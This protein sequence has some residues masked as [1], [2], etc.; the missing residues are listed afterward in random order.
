MRCQPRFSSRRRAA[1]FT[2]I[3]LMIGVLIG[4]LA[5]LAVTQVMVNAEGQKRSTTSGS[6]AQVNGALALRTLQRE[7]A[8][9]GYGFAAVPSVIGCALTATFNAAPIAGFSNVLAPIVITP[10]A[11][12]N[13]PDTIRVLASGK[14][15][16]S[17]PLRIVSPGYN[18]TVVATSTEFPVATVRTVEGPSATSPGDLMVAVI[19]AASPCEV[20]RVTADPAVTPVVPRADEG[21]KWNRT[22][23]PTQPYGDGSFLINMGAMV[24]RTFTVGTA[25]SALQ[26]KTL[27]I[28]TDS[29]PSYEGP[30]DLFP[31][32]VNLKAMYGKATNPATPQV[33]DAWDNAVPTTNA[34]WLQVLAVRVAV[35]SR[36][37]QY[38]K[39]PVTFA[40]PSWDVG[41]AVVI[42]GT[43][44]CGAS[45]CLA[46]KVDGPTDWQH[47]R[48]KV[49]DTVIPLRNMLWNS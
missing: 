20:F 1:G 16:Y 25:T 46:L 49:F 24:D 45:K 5:S 27:K 48:Y 11:T 35:V 18:P 12:A 36:S 17:L 32:I 47:Y 28:A 37:A 43:T 13:D 26:Q 7:L 41:T 19:S 44:A 42:P 30:V 3:E 9:A 21:A 10:G 4:L 29:T 23:Y 6:D 34:Q 8:P 31:N 2:L 40:N 39:D 33:I 22:G 38:E 14:S 15:S